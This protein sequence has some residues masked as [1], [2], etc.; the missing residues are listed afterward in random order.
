MMF[1]KLSKGTQSGFKCYAMIWTVWKPCL[2][3]AN[4]NS[5]AKGHSECA[6]RPFPFQPR[7]LT[8]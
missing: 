2:V 8:K 1:E 5:H 4:N 6:S 7:R 3:C